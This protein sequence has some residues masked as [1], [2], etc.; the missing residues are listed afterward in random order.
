MKQ[1]EFRL[2]RLF[3]FADLLLLLA[4]GGSSF[5]FYG[6]RFWQNRFIETGPA[7]VVI[8]AGEQIVAQLDLS[9]DTTLSVKG[10]LGDVTVVVSEGRVSF[11][12]SHCPLKICE[13]TGEINSKGQIIVCAPNKVLAKVVG[14]GPEDSGSLDGVSR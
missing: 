12:N 14:S 5:A 11:V 3:T 13:K 7:R 6:F 8:Q 1:R 4:V 2:P 9:Q 10:S